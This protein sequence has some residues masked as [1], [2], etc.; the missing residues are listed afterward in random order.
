MTNLPPRYLNKHI[1]FDESGNCT[2]Y[3][4]ESL[5]FSSDTLP[6]RTATITD[7]ELIHEFCIYLRNPDDFITQEMWVLSV[8]YFFMNSPEHMSKVN[9]WSAVADCEY[10]SYELSR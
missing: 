4:I 3:E 10:I 1:G 8:E 6:S 9:D 5:V 2:A 7:A